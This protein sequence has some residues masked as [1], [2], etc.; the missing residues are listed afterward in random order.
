MMT[1]MQPSRVVPIFVLALLVVVILTQVLGAKKNQTFDG[2]IVQNFATYEFYPNA[3]DCNYRGTPY[4]LLPNAR[5]SDTVA[6]VST[7]LAHLER[8]FHGVWRAKLN[9]N[10]SR[11]GL[12]KYNSMYWRKL[13]VNFVVDA[14]S[15]RCDEV[16]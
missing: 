1:T 4:L 14:D 2:V 3:K 9:G 5:F 12:Y 16:R 7:D 11:V 10:L 6:P 15:M 13:S 8:V